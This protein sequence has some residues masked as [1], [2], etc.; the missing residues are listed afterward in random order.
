MIDKK[1]HAFAKKIVAQLD[2]QHRAGQKSIAITF[3]KLRKH[4]D[5][6]KPGFK[7]S[8][9][10]VSL[11]SKAP[12]GFT[13][14]ASGIF[15]VLLKKSGALRKLFG[16][17]KGLILDHVR[18]HAKDIA[19]DVATASAGVLAKRAHRLL[20]SGKAKI[21]SRAGLFKKKVDKH[22][23]DS[24]T[25]VHAFLGRSKQGAGLKAAAVRLFS[26]KK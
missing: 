20:S 23:D 4:K 25:R 19:K 6:Y 13:K 1:M 7:P 2:K 10:R 9:R 17:T 11:P 5:S 16:S 18:K 15:G 24:A 21:I 26:K 8:G 12:K 14:E 22:V 3:H